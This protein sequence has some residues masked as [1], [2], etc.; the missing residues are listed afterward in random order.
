M[1]GVILAV[2]G[3]VSKTNKPYFYFFYHQNFLLQLLFIVA[4]HDKH[5]NAR[6]SNSS[7]RES[8]SKS[9]RQAEKREEYWNNQSGSRDMA[10]ESDRLE[11]HDRRKIVDGEIIS[12]EN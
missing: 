11:I 6:A 1:K 2:P 9:N 10:K 7:V 8:S 5:S 4:G 12:Q 3:L